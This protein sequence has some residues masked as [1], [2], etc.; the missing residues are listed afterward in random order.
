MTCF[1]HQPPNHL[2]FSTDDHVPSQVPCLFRQVPL[3]I[4]QAK[5]TLT[6]NS[7]LRAYQYLKVKC[8][9]VIIHQQSHFHVCLGLFKSQGKLRLDLHK[10]DLFSIFYLGIAEEPRS[11]ID[12]LIS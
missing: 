3:Q 7:S 2:P 5:G 1:R 8:P 11:Q 12:I 9:T 4:P 10:S 6:D